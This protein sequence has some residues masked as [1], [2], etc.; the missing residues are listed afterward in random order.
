MFSPLPCF[1][2]SAPSSLLRL[3]LPPPSS[4]RPYGAMSTPF[5]D[6]CGRYEAGA[7][8]GVFTG[9]TLRPTTTKK[10]LLGVARAL[11]VE[12]CWLGDVHVRL[13]SVQNKKSRKRE[14]PVVLDAQK[15]RAEEFECLKGRSIFAEHQ[16]HAPAFL[17]DRV[18]TL[19]HRNKSFEDVVFLLTV[20]RTERFLRSNA[21][22]L[23][24]GFCSRMAH[25]Q[26]HMLDTS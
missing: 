3:L 14:L 26:L 10:M 4:P 9:L 1:L 11:G 8:P 16:T 24:R 5:V 19:A 23:P 2:P 12:I 15:A 21:M 18:R 22:I 25:Q 17:K 7:E 13:R 6:G 20:S